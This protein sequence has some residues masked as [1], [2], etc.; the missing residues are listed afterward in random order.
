MRSD[1][2]PGSA[3]TRRRTTASR[4]RACRPSRASPGAAE[5]RVA[6]KIRRGEALGRRASAARR[7]TREPNRTS[8]SDRASAATPARNVELRARGDAAAIGSS[9]SGR[10]EKLRLLALPRRVGEQLADRRVA[11]GARRHE[12]ADRIVE[13]DPAVG[14][15]PQRERRRRSPASCRRGGRACRS[16]PGGCARRPAG[17]TSLPRSRRWDRQSRPPGPGIRP[18]SEATSRYSPNRDSRKSSAACTSAPAD[19]DRAI[20]SRS[21]GRRMN[22]VWAGG[23]ASY[24]RFDSST[25]RSC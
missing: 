10:Y 16:G 6:C 9:R 19:N 24:P 11:F 22:M 13:R 18:A 4:G 25:R 2:T 21:S 1:P 23:S 14:R 7:R 12:L 5:R 15:A 17:R 20:V 8:T 3:S